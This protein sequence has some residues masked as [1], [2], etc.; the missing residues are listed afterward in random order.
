M[1]NNEFSVEIVTDKT[2]FLEDSLNIS[3]KFNKKVSF[4]IHIVKIILN[5]IN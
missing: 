2:Y 3:Y 1:E 5:I 4:I